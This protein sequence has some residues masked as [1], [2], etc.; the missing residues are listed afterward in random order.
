MFVATLSTAVQF[1]IQLKS[2]TPLKSIE[3]QES[4]LYNK[5]LIPDIPYTPHQLH[6]YSYSSCSKKLKLDS[7]SN[8]RHF[9]D[10]DL[11]L[12]TF[13]GRSNSSDFIQFFRFPPSTRTL[14][15][16]NSFQI[17]NNKCSAIDRCMSAFNEM[18]IDLTCLRQLSYPRAKTLAH[19][20]PNT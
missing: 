5:N 12:K 1:G 6:T 11:V 2:H 13:T 4:L 15:R 20:R 10:I 19:Y 16:P 7:L 18:N 14:R 3:S 8:H 9:F 17:P